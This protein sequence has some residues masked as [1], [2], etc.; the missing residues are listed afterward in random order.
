MVS[1]LR[2]L[3]ALIILANTASV[4]SMNEVIEVKTNKITNLVSSTRTNDEVTQTIIIYFNSGPKSL[5]EIHTICEKDS[6]KLAQDEFDHDGNYRGIA[7]ERI[8]NLIKSTLDKLTDWKSPLKSVDFT[9]KNF[10]S[11]EQLK[12]IGGWIQDINPLLESSIFEINISITLEYNNDFQSAVE[13]SQRR[14]ERYNN[15]QY[16]YGIMTDNDKPIKVDRDR[17]QTKTTFDAIYVSYKKI[18][19]KRKEEREKLLNEMDE[20]ARQFMIDEHLIYESDGSDS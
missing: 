7:Q 15:W 11:L 3:G 10:S 12:L 13:E 8:D 14:V 1:S 5:Y 2:I 20:N 9:F 17:A 19:S 4:K 6:K 16:S 18:Q